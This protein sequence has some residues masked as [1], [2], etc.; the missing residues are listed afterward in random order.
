MN[1][2]TLNT[3]YIRSMTEEDRMAV[4]EMMRIFYASEATFTNGSDEIFNN[5]I[6][7]CVS[8]SPFAEGFVFVFPESVE[9][10]RSQ[11]KILG[12]AMLAH[13]FSTEFGKN[14]VWIEDIYFME[15]ARGC[16]LASQFFDL[17][18]ERYPDSVN[19]LEAEYEN[20]HAM[21]VY[22]RKGFSELPYVEMIRGI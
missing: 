17:V 2:N 3:P 12:Y 16:G 22:R 1:D 8:D 19:R 20:I 11:E 6:T 14:C 13:S 10:D 18:E 9:N 7:A 4:L 15:E 21:E 5:D